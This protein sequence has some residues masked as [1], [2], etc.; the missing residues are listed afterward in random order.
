MLHRKFRDNALYML[1][2]VILQN[3]RKRKISNNDDN[4]RTC[5]KWSYLFEHWSEFYMINMQNIQF[6]GICSGI[7]IKFVVKLSGIYKLI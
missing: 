7:E 6:T 3:W 5:H 4:G 1:T 2:N